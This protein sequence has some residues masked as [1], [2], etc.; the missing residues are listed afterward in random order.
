MKGAATPFFRCDVG[1]GFGEIPSVATK[2]TSVVLAL[3]IRLI[4]GFSQDNGAILPRALAVGFGIFDP[5]LNDVRVVRRGAAFSNRE[6]ALANLHLDMVVR[7]TK[8]NG[9]AKGL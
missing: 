5:D 8:T 4:L 2:V 9:E 3:A 6:A 1:N 7:D